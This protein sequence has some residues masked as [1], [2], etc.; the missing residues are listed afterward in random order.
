MTKKDRLTNRFRTARRTFPW[1]DFC[2]LMKQLGYVQQEMAG[3]RVRFT[4]PEYPMILLHRPHPGN[5][6]KGAAL[7]SVQQLLKQEGVI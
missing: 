3:S 5:E 4:H 6:I 1:R 2:V 7:R